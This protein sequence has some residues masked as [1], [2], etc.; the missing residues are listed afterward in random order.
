MVMFVGDDGG[1][2]L[3][4]MMVVVVIVF[5]V[6]V[7]V[8]MKTCPNAGVPNPRAADRYRSGGHVVPG[9]GILARSPRDN[10]PTA[11]DYSA[12]HSVIAG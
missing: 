8:M 9:G 1:D 6:V 4:R 12:G 11:D 3:M 2:S 5:M 10:P 7:V